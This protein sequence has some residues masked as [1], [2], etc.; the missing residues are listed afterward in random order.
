[1]TLHEY[2]KEIARLAMEY[3][4]CEVWYASDDEGNS[5]TPVTYRPSVLDAS[6]IVNPAR[7]LKSKR[8]VVVN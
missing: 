3:G 6:A 7:E 4:E 5:Y 2:A 8:V 1:M